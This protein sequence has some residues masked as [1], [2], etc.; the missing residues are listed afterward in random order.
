MM[1]KKKEDE[2]HLKRKGMWNGEKSTHT[3]TD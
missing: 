3:H 2:K 1:V